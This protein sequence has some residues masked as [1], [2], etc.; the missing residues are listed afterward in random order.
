[1]QALWKAE[2]KDESKI[3][4]IIKQSKMYCDKGGLVALIKKGLLKMVSMKKW[5]VEY[6]TSRVRLQSLH[7]A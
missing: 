7:H 6:Y 2:G 3:L 1:M 4:P 5:C